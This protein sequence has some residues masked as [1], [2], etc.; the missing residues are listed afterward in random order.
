MADYFEIHKTCKQITRKYYWLTF[1]KDV[2]AYVKKY[3]ICLA[4]KTVMHK[5]YN[6]LSSLQI[7]IHRWKKLSIDFVMS[8][9]ILMN[10]NKDRYDAILNI[11]DYLTKIIYYE[12]IKIIIDIASLAEIVID[13]MVKYHNI[14][15]SIISDKSPLFTFIF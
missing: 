14:S 2:K 9:S 4:L 13:L 15:K 12:L 5:R 11:V 1:C 7:F 8:L 6:D 3:D 10:W